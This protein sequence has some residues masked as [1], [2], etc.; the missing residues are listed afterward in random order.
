MFLKIGSRIR[1]ALFS[2]AALCCGFSAPAP[3]QVNFEVGLPSAEI[4]LEIQQYPKLVRVPRNPVYYARDL[5]SNLFFYDGQYWVY[6]QDNWY[7]SAWYDG[8]WD[9]VPP[10]AVPDFILRIPLHYY[11]RPPPYFSDWDRHSPPHWEEHWGH[12]WEER[13]RGWNHWNPHDVPR[14]AP[15]PVYPP[16]PPRA[17][18]PRFEEQQSPGEHN[19]PHEPQG[20]WARHRSDWPKSGAMDPNPTREPY[21]VPGI[22]Q[23]PDASTTNSKGDPEL[24]DRRGNSE[25]PGSPPPPSRSTGDSDRA[26]PNHL[27]PRHGTPEMPRPQVGPGRADPPSKQNPSKPPPGK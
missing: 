5:D 21:R 8:P 1:T 27:V 19:S 4:G 24:Q 23:R 22:R 25:R 3:A 12:D 17:E 9:F 11:R 16:P 6:A 20:D 10:E 15:A 7:T 18:F 2:V 26:T 13:R 14:R